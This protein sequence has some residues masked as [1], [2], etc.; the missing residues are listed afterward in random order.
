MQ[1]NLSL[2]SA[3]LLTVV[4]TAAHAQIVSIPDSGLN[5]AIRSALHIPSAPLTAQDLL[6]LTNLD[7]RARNIRSLQGLE[8]A[9]K[10]VSLDLQINHLTNFSLPQL[11][12]LLYLDLSVNQLPGSFVLNGLTN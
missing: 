4:I 9:R 10:L 1:K 3:L 6:T 5:A 7:A 12:N 2:L 11:T 8:A